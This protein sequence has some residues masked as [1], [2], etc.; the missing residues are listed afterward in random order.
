MNIANICIKI[1]EWFLHSCKENKVKLPLKWKLTVML[2]ICSLK[3]GKFLY[4]VSKLLDNINI[5]IDKENNTWKVS[6]KN[7]IDDPAF[8]KRYYD[9]IDAIFK[10]HPEYYKEWRLSNTNIIIDTDPNAHL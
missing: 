7:K 5:E 2:V 6:S 3:A 1:L 10:S 8:Q 4:F 9:D